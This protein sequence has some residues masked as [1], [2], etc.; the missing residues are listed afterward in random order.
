MSLEFLDQHL[1]QLANA[2]LVFRIS[3]VDDLAVASTIL[4]FDDPE[5]AVDTLVDLRETSLLKTA[6]DQ[7]NRCSLDQI[8]YQ[9]RDGPGG[10]DPCRI[11]R[12]ES[13]TD[14]VEGSEETELEVLMLAIGPDHPIQQLFGT[15][16]DPSL[17]I[18]RAGNE[19][20]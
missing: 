5:K 6:I 18:D 2:C 15:G 16:I 14:P 17:T 11:E 4:V 9:L 10:T 12:V 20:G 19:C 3:D 8:E 7:E 1:R 13:R